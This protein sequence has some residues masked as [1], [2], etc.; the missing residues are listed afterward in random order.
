[1]TVS[2]VLVA[3]SIGLMDFTKM[4]CYLLRF[5][6]KRFLGFL[7]KRHQGWLYGSFKFQKNKMVS[8]V[9]ALNALYA[10]SLEYIFQPVKTHFSFK[11]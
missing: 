4:A 1:M 9:R 2:F 10:I 6:S 3:F 7:L 5:R 11:M 8:S